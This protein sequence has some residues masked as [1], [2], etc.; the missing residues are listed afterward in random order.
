MRAV[1]LAPFVEQSQD[2]LNFL[3]QQAV[4]R[5]PARC[6]VGQPATGT[7][8]DPAVRPPLGQLQ[9]LTDPAQ[10]PVGRKRLVQQVEQACLGG[11]A[12]PAGDPAT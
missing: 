5:G 8:G 4:H 10:C 7:A 9:L 11:R 12:H 1:D 3:G 2:R 6:P